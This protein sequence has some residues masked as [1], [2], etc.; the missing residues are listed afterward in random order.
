[1]SVNRIILT[2]SIWL[3]MVANLM[4]LAGVAQRADAQGPAAGAAISPTPW[5]F[6]HRVLLDYS[7]DPDAMN[8]ECAIV[9][10]DGDGHPDLWWSCYVFLTDKAAYDRQKD[11]YQMAWYK[12][13]DFKQM[14]RMHKGVTHGG[15]WCDINGD[16]RMDLVTGLAI[17]SHDLVWLEN[18]GHCERTRDWPMHLIHHGEVDPDTILFGDLNHDGRLDAV[19]QSFRNDVHVLLAPADPVDGKWEIFHAGHSD[20]LRTGAS[21]GDVN[22]DGNLDIV[23][24]RGWLENPDDLRLP[25]KDHVI[26]PEFGYDAQSVVVDLDRDR[27]PDVVLASEEGFDGVAWYNWDA[28]QNKWLKHQIAPA[29]S[30]SGLHSLR[31]ADFDGDGDVDVFTAEMAMSGYITQEPPHKVTVWENVDIKKNE[32]REHI[33]AETGLHNAR[34]GDID[35]D[36]LPDV[37]GSNWNNRLKEYPM[38]AEIWINRIGQG[39][40]S[41]SEE[42][43]K[44]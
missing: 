18:P 31:I 16:G 7:I 19:V 30:Y 26:D 5:R 40:S 14:F 25:W 17:E 9:D 34:V 8:G 33:L 29:K 6:E 24:G 39:P 2:E 41:R 20:H 44:P 36:G 1:M 28:V 10:I 35:G 13:S 11:L 38:K 22:A 21:I 42:R 27:H 32:W 15:S 4:G 37:I 23:W 12:G 43:T 3:L